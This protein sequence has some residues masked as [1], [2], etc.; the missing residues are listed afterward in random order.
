[1]QPQPHIVQFTACQLLTAHKSSGWSDRVWQYKSPWCSN[2]LLHLYLRILS[3]RTQPLIGTPANSDLL[4]AQRLASLWTFVDLRKLRWMFQIYERDSH[5]CLH[6][7]PFQGYVSSKLAFRDVLEKHTLMLLSCRTQ[8][9]ILLVSLL[10]SKTGLDGDWLG[11]CMPKQLLPAKG[12]F[13][14]CVFHFVPFARRRLSLRLAT[15]RDHI[16]WLNLY[17]PI[18][19]TAWLWK[20]TICNRSQ[21]CTSKPV[22]N[23][24]RRKTTSLCPGPRQQSWWKY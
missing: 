2:Q 14:V 1:M 13:V 10:F 17:R 23:T 16:S 5:S 21:S 15:F 18:S 24:G 9:S 4:A 3:K 20:V 12:P 8:A 7:A 6:I 19:K 11:R 22:S